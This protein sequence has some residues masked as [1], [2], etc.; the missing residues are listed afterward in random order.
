MV[1]EKAGV[2][3]T[4]RFIEDLEL[5]AQSHL[6]DSQLALL[7]YVRRDLLLKEIDG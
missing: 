3:E 1:L 5:M 4:D 6:L 7:C 2:H